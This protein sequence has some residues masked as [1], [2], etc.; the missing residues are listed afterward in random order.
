MTLNL[1]RPGR[2]RWCKRE[3]HGAGV[4][5]A[6]DARRLSEMNRG[7]TSDSCRYKEVPGQ[8]TIAGLIVQS[9]EQSGMNVKERTRRSRGLQ[10]VNFGQYMLCSLKPREK[11]RDPWGR[12]SARY[13]YMFVHLPHSGFPVHSQNKFRVCLPK[14]F[15]EFNIQHPSSRTP[16][17]E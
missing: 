2:P 17:L 16:H 9:I 13:H 6:R 10:Q 4:W 1:L 3:H 8:G 14:F 7:G 15:L 11:H 5:S 12:H